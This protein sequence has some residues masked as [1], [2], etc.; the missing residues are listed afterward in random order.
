PARRRRRL[1][2]HADDRRPAARRRDLPAHRRSLPRSRS[3]QPRVV[4]GGARVAAR[5]AEGPR[6]ARERAR[7][8]RR[9]RQG[10]LRIRP[11][12]HPVLPRPGTPPTERADVRLS[13]SRRA[14]LRP[15]PFGR[16]RREAGE[17]IGWVRHADRAGGK[18][19]RARRVPGPH[20]GRPAELHRAAADQALHRP[21]D[22]RRPRR[23][24]A[25][26]SASVH[27]AGRADVG[28]A[29]RAHARGAER[30]YWMGRYVER[31]ESTARLVSAYTNQVMDLPRGVEPGWKHL[32]DITGANE[33]FDSGAA[34]Y[35]ER[36]TISFLVADRENAG[37]ILSSVAAA[38]ENVRTTRDVLPTEVWEYANELYLFAQANAQHA[39]ARGHRF[40]VLKSIVSRCQQLEGLLAGTMSHGVA[41]E[42]VSLGRNLERADMTT[43][44]VDSAVFLLM[45]RRAAPGAYDSILWMN[46]LRSLGGYQMYRQHVRNK[47]EAD[48]VVR[49]LLYARDFPRAVCHALAESERG[50]GTF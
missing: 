19:G 8:G 35:D 21:D 29:G 30:V 7:C 39:V 5:V 49:F 17:R 20:H 45:P 24:A 31:A 40:R 44:I 15:R 16:A 37:S 34:T 13:R 18:R 9:R 41:Y 11:G 10:R 46:V 1:R 33:H 12:H 32:V 26:R 47:V 38:R 14:G 48:E 43:R 50:L 3:L 42:F 28:D 22:R 25:R 4:P 6:R 36:S 2:V 27:P 23:A